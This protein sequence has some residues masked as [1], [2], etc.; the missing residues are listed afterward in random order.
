MVNS[1]SDRNLL[2][3][4]LALQMDFIDRDQLVAAMNAWVLD[5]SQSL[6]QLLVER[7][8]LEDDTRRI[9][10]ALVDKHLA[11]HGGDAAKSL[12]RVPCDVTVRDELRRLNDTEV[13]G[14]LR[15]AS[16]TVQGPAADLTLPARAP[17]P[18]TAAQRYHVLRPHAQG[19]LG[20]VSVA[21]D[22]ELNREVALKELLGRHADDAD[23]RARFLLEAELT[24]A[25]EHPGVVPV[26][27]LGQYDDGR[28]FYAMRFIRGD[29]FKEAIQRYHGEAKSLPPGER[30]LGMRKLLGQFIDVCNAVQ[31]AHS[32]GVL[33]RDLKP[34][35]IMLGKYG[36]TLVVDWGLAK[37]LG[38]SVGKIP[39]SDGTLRLPAAS[40]TTAT[41]VGSVVGTPAYMS[42]EQAAG[43]LD[44]MGPSSDVYSLGATL[45]FVLTGTPAFNDKRVADVLHKVERGEFPRPR[46]IAPHV[47]GALEAI[48][49]KAMSLRREDR[50]GSPRDLAEDIEHWL[51]DEPVAAYREP[52]VERMGRWTRRHRAWTQAIAASLLLVAAVGVTAAVIVDGARRNEADERQRAVA[53]RLRAE[54]LADEKAGLVEEKEAALVRVGLERDRAEQNFTL[55]RNAVDTYLT[56]VA[57]APELKVHGLQSLRRQLLTTAQSYYEQLAAQKG[58]DP[59][60]QTERGRALGRLGLIHA[61]LGQVE[62]SV[63]HFRQSIAVFD[64]LLEHDPSSPVLRELAAFCRMSLAEMLVFDHRPSD[65]Q[66]P[67]Q[68]ALE[69]FAGL[70]E[71][72]PDAPAFRS[73]LARAYLSEAERLRHLNRLEETAEALGQALEMRKELADRFPEYWG[74]RYDLVGSQ[75][76]LAFHYI[77]VQW[78]FTKAEPPLLAAKQL[79]EEI[80]LERPNE[81]Y[82]RWQ[83]ARALR[84]L[85]ACY[86]RTLRAGSAEAE[87]RRAEE[88]CAALIDEHPQVPMFAYELAVCQY[89]RAQMYVAQFRY[90]EG[91]EAGDQA[92]ATMG[93]LADRYPDNAEYR[94]LLAQCHAHVGDSRNRS[95]DREQAET[96]LLAALR[97]LDSLP[98]TSQKVLDHLLTV[99][100]S[101][102]LLGTICSH[103]ER[104]QEAEEHYALAIQILGQILDSSPQHSGARFTMIQV[105]IDRATMREA[106]GRIADAMA[107]M[108][109]ILEHAEKLGSDHTEN[110]WYLP[111]MRVIVPTARLWVVT[112]APTLRHDLLEQVREGEYE[113]AARDAMRVA[114]L[115]GDDKDFIHGARV[116]ALAS[117][118]AAGD[119]NLDE[120]QRRERSEQLAGQ[121]VELLEKARQAGV[122]DKPKSIAAVLS[123]RFTANTI[124]RSEDFAPLLERDDLRALLERIER[125]E[126]DDRTPPPPPDGREKGDGHL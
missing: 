105:H 33:H 13:A 28:P 29:S 77:Y 86:V 104:E 23:N 19:G 22:T 5:K 96:H 47:P 74:Y 87:L 64:P 43:K 2:T 61:E 122:F 80:Y 34:D 117:A 16:R 78:E 109:F 53:A 115:T 4:I 56:N 123:T 93:E 50:Y 52:A 24:G 54:Q 11:L 99:A 7:G 112:S 91:A 58:D 42:P 57:E 39:L 108:Q 126:P 125:P 102:V 66:V 8:D 55:A 69:T 98:A 67:M 31:Y 119:E 36:E 45:Y 83:L 72:F 62:E 84:G 90:L 14:S 59:E 40:G 51:A 116:L 71:E 27:G 37:W 101:R 113:R 106:E 124:R 92:V 41:Q 75:I 30:A 89:V 111:I 20:A 25:L 76:A 70:V 49:L 48:C 121:S 60:F 12:A 65:A 73:Y 81:P 18:P 82:V 103:T 9:L 114:D 10:N 63:N 32:R 15:H 17:L 88:L 110:D 118:A 3:G 100:Q 79:S 97:E 21:E 38:R 94:L 44:T 68:K 85:A 120:Q 1:T 35:N 46:Q 26:Y 107:D 6:D 95:G